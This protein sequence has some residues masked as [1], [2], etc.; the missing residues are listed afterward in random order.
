M[1]RLAYFLIPAL[2][3]AGLI[4]WRFTENKHKQTIQVQAANARKKAPVS[5]RVSPATVRDIVHLFQAVGNVESPADVRIA[6]KV[7]GRL[8]YLNVREGA[9]V[10]RGEVLARID[11]SE[12]QAALNQQ[13]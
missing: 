11:P 13:L 3:L 12:A 9:H 10:T 1:K 8:D 4:V 6:A 7:T 2:V 5:V